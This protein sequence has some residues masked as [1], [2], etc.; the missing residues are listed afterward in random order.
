MHFFDSIKN[1]LT[2]AVW[3]FR[4]RFHPRHRYHV[5]NTMDKWGKLNGVTYGWEEV[6]HQM[7]YACFKLLVDYVEKQRPFGI[8]DFDDNEDSSALKKEILDLY[9]WWTVTRPKEREEVAEGWGKIPKFRFDANVVWRPHPE[10]AELLKRNKELD[11]KDDEM[12]SRLVRIRR[13][14]WT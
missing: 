3:W 7:M 10:A 11:D 2:H 5:I 1:K 4:Y 13:S 14:L 12:L 8:I 9:G 6:D